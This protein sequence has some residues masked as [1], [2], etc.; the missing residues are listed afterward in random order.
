M[1]FASTRV[2][3]LVNWYLFLKITQFRSIK[4]VLGLFQVL[5]GFNVFNCW[6]QLKKM[7]CDNQFSTEIWCV[8]G[9]VLTVKYCFGLLPLSYSSLLSNLLCS[10]HPESCVKMFQN[11]NDTNATCPSTIYQ[12][13]NSK[14]KPY[15]SLSRHS[16]SHNHAWTI[17]HHHTP[18]LL[19]HT[20]L[21]LLSSSYQAF[22][23]ANLALMRI[24][25]ILSI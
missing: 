24:L 10:Q 25:F 18:S 15:N 5:L 13:P 6:M 3:L 4:S 2:F 14:E 8:I 16:S 21:C 7:T 11:T 12:R 1:T 22:Y 20:Q 17:K 19:I 23:E 9:I